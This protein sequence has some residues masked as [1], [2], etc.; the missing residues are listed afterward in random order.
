V[1]ILYTIVLDTYICISNESLHFGHTIYKTP[2]NVYYLF[3]AWNLSMFEYYI[4]YRHFENLMYN[5][6]NQFKF[7]VLCSKKL[8]IRRTN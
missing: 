2:S 5:D 7:S 3:D 6:I 1:T 4:L 8:N